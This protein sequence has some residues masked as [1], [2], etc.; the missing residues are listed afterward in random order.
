MQSLIKWN[1]MEEQILAN[2]YGKI[3]YNSILKLLPNKTYD[4]L[5]L[6]K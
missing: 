3:A 6:A 4:Q 1:I 2:N 5:R